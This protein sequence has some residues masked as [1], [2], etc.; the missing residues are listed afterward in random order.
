[1]KAIGFLKGLSVLVV[2][3]LLAG[4]LHAEPLAGG[5]AKA[6][7]QPDAAARAKAI[8]LFSAAP[9]AFIENAGQ[10]DDP[11]IRYAF[12]GSGANVFHTTSGPV[13]QVFAPDP[14]APA[15]MD[16]MDR[17]DRMDANELLASPC[18]RV[19]GSFF[20]PTPPI[21]HSPSLFF[22]ASSRPRVLTFSASFPGARQIKPVGRQLL[23]TK[24]NYCLGADHGKWREGVPTF[25]AFEIDG[26][27]RVPDG[28][29]IAAGGGV[30]RS[31]GPGAG[32]GDAGNGGGLDG[33]RL[34]FCHLGHE[35]AS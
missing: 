35:G 11:S 31:A 4:P 19:S 7:A 29:L 3:I 24:I 26:A 34:C 28:F 16:A 23:E 13:F 30:G 10:L 14:D 25:G 15:Q 20:S 32:E 21:P 9:A 22:P 17:M 8:Q 18:P 27:A 5:Y 6:P 33:E 2:S 12:H 1:M